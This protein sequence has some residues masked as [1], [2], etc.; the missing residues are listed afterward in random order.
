M[1]PTNR[2]GSLQK[3]PPTETER[4]F[5]S[6][7]LAPSCFLA[8]ARKMYHDG[9]ADLFVTMPTLDGPTMRRLLILVSD[10]LATGITDVVLDCAAVKGEDVTDVGL[11]LVVKLANQLARQPRTGSL[12][13]ALCGA[14]LLERLAVAD[15]VLPNLTIKPAFPEV[16]HSPEAYH[17]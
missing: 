6:M 8:V 12:T 14:E 16:V 11:G 2:A 4:R 15:L 17:T 7:L 3:T 13:L 5:A 10:Q 1:R 9:R